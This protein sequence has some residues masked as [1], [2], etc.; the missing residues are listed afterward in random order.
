MSTASNPESDHTVRN[1]IIG[2][3]AVVLLGLGYCATRV[4]SLTHT[5]IGAAQGIQGR[6]DTT[7]HVAPGSAV[8]LNGTKIADIAAVVV[9]R[10]DTTPA[11]AT[12]GIADSVLQATLRQETVV[13][14]VTA[15]TPAVAAQL[16]DLTLIGHKDGTYDDSIPVQ[17][18]LTHRSGA[19]SLAPVQLKV[20]G[21]SLPISVY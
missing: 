20:P 19:A 14:T 13:Y 11:P 7:H 4:A 8:F 21:R 2:I 5:M 3:V 16:S 12:H 9:I 15:T 1:V 6:M 17:I 10:A 18:T